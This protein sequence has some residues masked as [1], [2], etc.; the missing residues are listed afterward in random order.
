MIDLK[1]EAYN[2]VR[3]VLR[4]GWP[5]SLSHKILML[6]LLVGLVHTSAHSQNS[7][8]LGLHTGWTAHF[9]NISTANPGITSKTAVSSL[10]WNFGTDI[11]LGRRAAYLHL[12]IGTFRPMIRYQYQ[13]FSE[14]DI[15]ALLTRGFSI[16]AAFK[17]KLNLWKNRL[18]AV[19][20]AG[21]QIA[22][23]RGNW[24]QEIQFTDFFDQNTLVYS[25]IYTHPFNRNF[26]AFPMAGLQLEY[27]FDFGLVLSV[28][29]F[30]ARGLWV[31]NE[32][33]ISNQLPGQ[34][35]TTAGFV[36]R[37]THLPVQ[38]GI[39]YAVSRIWGR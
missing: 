2:P 28:R 10:D 31:I 4:R 5:L 15:N 21:V 8:Y 24:D 13:D 30:Y 18:F 6:L 33:I 7:L 27:A 29:A 20:L 16:Q 23:Y 26:A 32:G 22:H 1:T 9:P 11:R 25:S 17:Y 39:G 36:S 37:Y 35:P 19:P 3:P 14:G 12:G 38:F 34:Q